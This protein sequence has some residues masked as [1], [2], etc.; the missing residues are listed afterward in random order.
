MT[1]LLTPIAEA[2]WAKILG[3]A[4]PNKFEPNKAPTWSI[5]LLL[6]PQNPEHRDWMAVAEQHFVEAHGD[7]A[8]KS[9]HWLGLSV[10]KDDR[11]KM[12]AKFKLPCFTRKDLSKSPGP[13]VMDAAKQPW[14]H[15]KLIGNGSKVRICYTVYPWSG[16]IGAGV[17]LQPTHVQVLELVEYEAKSE[18]A[19]DPFEVEQ[20]GYKLDAAPAPAPAPAVAGVVV[21]DDTCPF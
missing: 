14:P 9:Q 7:N 21:T 3:D 4:E 12:V 11:T 17:T 10:D 16:P 5:E 13:T 8:K 18:V 19:V 2:R 20:T 6:D 15:T 1:A